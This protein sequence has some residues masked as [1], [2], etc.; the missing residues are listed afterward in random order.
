MTRKGID[1]VGK[2]DETQQGA[3]FDLYMRSLKRY[4]ES[5]DMK[6]LSLIGGIYHHHFSRLTFNCSYPEYADIA[7][8][9]TIEEKWGENVVK[10]YL[11]AQ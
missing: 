1:L 3:D 5:G 7:N 9:R 8:I 11:A 2:W 6:P 4:K 10:E